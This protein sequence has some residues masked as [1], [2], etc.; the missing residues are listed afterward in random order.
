MNFGTTLS[1][2]YVALVA[3]WLLVLAWPPEERS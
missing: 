3:G 2:I 1:I